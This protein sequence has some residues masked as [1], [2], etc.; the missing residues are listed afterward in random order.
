MFTRIEGAYYNV[1]SIVAA[2]PGGQ[3]IEAAVGIDATCLFATHHALCLSGGDSKARAWLAKC[4]LEPGSADEA[5]AKAAI[6][7]GPVFGRSSLF[8]ELTAAI[9]PLVNRQLGTIAFGLEAAFWWSALCVALY[10]HLVLHSLWASV[11]MPAVAVMIAL[12][13]M[14]EATHGG[15]ASPLLNTTV[16]LLAMALGAGGTQRWR[17]SHTRHHALTNDSHGDPD[18]FPFE[19]FIRYLPEIERQP[20]HRW[21]PYYAW[22][23]YAFAAHVFS[24]EA[25][26]RNPTPSFKDIVWIPAVADQR[27]AWLETAL[28]ATSLLFRVVVPLWLC[29]WRNLI[30]CE[31]A[32]LV[33]GL[34]MACV[35]Q[36]NHFTARTVNKRD[37]A[38]AQHGT[39]WA[40]MQIASSN[41]FAVDSTLWNHVCGGLNFQIEHHLYPTLNHWHYPVVARELHRI[42]KRRGIDITV[43]DTI[44]DAVADHQ[45][46]LVMMAT[47]GEDNDDKKKSS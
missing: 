1:A 11:L 2:H 32:M 10:G 9:K 33:A 46:L 13:T 28:G 39:D 23:I 16:N 30:A 25:A 8:D 31:L 24:V 42:C 19:R 6:L 37:A 7:A 15:T 38:L 3:I 12:T 18:I 43:Y 29:P 40:A 21:Q 35:F 45:K 27:R 36:V 5:A 4:R 22:L 14:H 34:F 26:S 20:H 44:W 17:F 41:D 47:G